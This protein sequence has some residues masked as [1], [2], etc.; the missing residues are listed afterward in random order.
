MTTVAREG[1]RVFPFPVDYSVPVWTTWDLGSPQNTVV[2]YWQRVGYQYRLIDCDHHL[3]NPDG[4]EMKTG[5]RVAHMMSKG[6]AYAGH[7]LPHD[8]QNK[9]YDAMSVA[10]RL[11]EAGLTNVKVI[12][13]A[14]RNAEENRVQVMSDLFP[15]IL[16]NEENLNDEGGLLEA[17]ENYHRKES[18][19]DGYIMNKIVHDWCSHFADSFGYFGEA[20]KNNM[21]MAGQ[22]SAAPRRRLVVRPKNSPSR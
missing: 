9:G 11:T 16:F 6:Y 18:K 15:S 21:I 20:L 2:C 14:S 5:Q 3:R 13:R 10:S 19:E 12:P 1:N 17:L 7:F 22:D 8:S 4:T